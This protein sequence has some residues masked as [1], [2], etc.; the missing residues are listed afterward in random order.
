MLKSRNH[1]VPGGWMYFQPE[2]NWQ[3]N[4]NV[5]FNDVVQQIVEH[6]KANPRFNLATDAATVERELEQYTEARLRSQF[7]EGANEYLINSGSPPPS[8]TPPRLRRHQAGAVAV[9]VAKAQRISAGIGL[10]IDWLGDGLKPVDQER[11]DQRAA[12]CAKCEFNQR[13]TLLEQLTTN[14][15]AAGIKSLL[16]ERAE[17]KLSTPHDEALQMCKKCDCVLKLKVFTPFKHVLEHT[18]KEVM[19]SLPSF[20]WIKSEAGIST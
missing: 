19:D 4:P 18:S 3:S 14:P 2:T 13:A 1:F 7:G 10:M 9:G 8:F 11:A 17:M 15:A 16:Q 5:G 20:C 12:I 6:R